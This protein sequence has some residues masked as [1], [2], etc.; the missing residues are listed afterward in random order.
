M[1]MNESAAPD[2]EVPVVATATTSDSAATV[3]LPAP[4]AG[5]TP[6]PEPPTD[7][8]DLVLAVLQRLEDRL[9]ESQ[10]LLARQTDIA[11]SLH[12]ENQRLRKG[13]L[14]QGQLPLVRDL[15]RVQDVIGHVLDAAVESAAAADLQIARD[16]ILDALARNGI[17]QTS[18]VPGDPLD[19]RVHK[20]VGVEHV[21]DPAADRTLAEIV[22][23]G[24]TWEDGMTI[25]AADVR[26]CKH[27][28]TTQSRGS[29]D[30]ASDATAQPL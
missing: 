19:P 15:I 2:P 11:T 7:P 25:R 22:R 14:R 18:D 29:R 12:A 30:L 10:R 16:S 5:A 20:V 21:D 1:S 17:E 9:E 8:L 23:A 26:A 3:P 24:F 4:A 6:E 28:P 27:T 13:E